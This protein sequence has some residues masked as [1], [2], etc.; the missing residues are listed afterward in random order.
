[1]N[2]HAERGGGHTSLYV[3]V[4]VVSLILT[5]I[6]FGILLTNTGLRSDAVPIII[7]L[8]IVQVALQVFLFMHLR[9]GRQVYRLFFGYGA[10]IAIVVA[11]GIGYVLTAYSPPTPKIPHLTAAQMVAQGASIVSTTCVSCHTVNGKGAPGPGPNLNSV[12]SGS[13]N[14]VPG[15]HPT[16]A[17]WLLQWIADPPGVWSGAKMPNLGLTPLQVKEV[18]A[19]LQKDVK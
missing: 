9:E 10:F 18:V 3:G 7:I 11:W 8:A 12:L 15:G 17:S 16:Q 2:A 1:M 13:L 5:A 19:Y 4:G 14:L 6:A